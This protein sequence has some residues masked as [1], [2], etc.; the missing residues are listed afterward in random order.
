[1]EQS[2]L[3]ME[4]MKTN[5]QLLL[6]SSTLPMLND[7]HKLRHDYRQASFMETRF[8]TPCP[9]TLNIDQLSIQTQETLRL[10]LKENHP[11]F[12]YTTFATRL[13]WVEV[14]HHRYKPYHFSKKD[15]HVH[16]GA[17]NPTSCN[18]Y[19]SVGYI[20]EIFAWPASE[21]RTYLCIAVYG[22]P[23]AV[24]DPFRDWPYCGA[25][26]VGRN[27]G[28]YVVVPLEQVIEPIAVCP[29]SKKDLVVISCPIS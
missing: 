22:P 11:G 19:G 5:L 7:L 23:S 16:F 3:R 18:L 1:M 13:P 12:K 14:Y 27:V 17:P 9:K 2:M 6:R 25:K 28:E 29:W 15:S 8:N 24:A 10:Y 4:T 20:H 21:P 26:L